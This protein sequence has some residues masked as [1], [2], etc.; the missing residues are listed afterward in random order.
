MSSKRSTGIAASTPARR[1]PGLLVLTV[2]N[3]SFSSS[4]RV[5]GFL[6]STRLLLAGIEPAACSARSGANVS[7]GP[8]LG[9]RLLS[10]LRAASHV[11]A[12]GPKH[13]VHWHPQSLAMLDSGSST[14][15]LRADVLRRAVSSLSRLRGGVL[16]RSTI[17]HRKSQAK[18]SS[19][20]ASNRAVACSAQR[21]NPSI[22]GT[23]N[24]RLRLLSAAPH[25]KR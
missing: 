5:G 10:L 11:V 6:P 25:V 1:S 15:A 4:S 20:L 18:V 13:G 3:P 21:P 7:A 19:V 17:T 8:S 22:E 12:P 24:I 2:S 23:S 9:V 14:R 16:L